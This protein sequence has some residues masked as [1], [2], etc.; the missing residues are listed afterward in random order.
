MPDGIAEADY[1]DVVVAPVGF[2]GVCEHEKAAFVE[3]GDAVVVGAA[4]AGVVVAARVEVGAA[5]DAPVDAVVGA[6]AAAENDVVEVGE[7]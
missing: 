2:V 4:A 6:A 3:P 7:V 5:F 1:G